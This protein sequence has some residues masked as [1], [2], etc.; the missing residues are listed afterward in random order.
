MIR[1]LWGRLV[2]IQVTEEVKAGSEACDVKQAVRRL[3]PYIEM[4]VEI[5]AETKE[6]REIVRVIE[7]AWRGHAE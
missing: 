3:E 2:L 5:E 7:E 4:L 6:V 1:E